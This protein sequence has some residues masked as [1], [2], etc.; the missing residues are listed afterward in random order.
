MT[1]KD[2]IKKIMGGIEEKILKDLWLKVGKKSL[3]IG[4]RDGEE[5]CKGGIG[6]DIEPKGDNVIKMDAH[7]MEFNKE[8][9][10]VVCRHSLEH[11]YNPYLVLK[12]IRK[13]L[14]PDGNLILILPNPEAKQ[15][16]E[17][18]YCWQPECITSL[19]EKTGF[20]VERID[21]T[22]YRLKPLFNHFPLPIGMKLSRF[23][24]SILM[25]RKY[26]VYARKKSEV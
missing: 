11:F 12:K 8:F 4:C 3:W 10:T 6:I 21:Y 20:T 15:I 1:Q 19:L 18:Y 9:N 2:R 14:K 16:K 5:I 22:N 17:H 25:K 23:F 7:N 24:G 26:R 13:A